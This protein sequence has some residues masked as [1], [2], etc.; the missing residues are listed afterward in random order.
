MDGDTSQ[1]RH[2]WTKSYKNA[3]PYFE[4]ESIPETSSSNFNTSELDATGGNLL[5]T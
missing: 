5:K 3:S 4:K 2:E 1:S